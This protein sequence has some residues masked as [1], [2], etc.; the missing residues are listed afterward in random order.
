MADEE[1]VDDGRALRCGR[2]TPEL[3][4]RMVEIERRSFTNPWSAADF[5]QVLGDST[6]VCVGMALRETLIGY[7]IG[8]LDG[9]DFHLANLAVDV[10][11]RRRGWGGRLLYTALTEAR[12]RKCQSCSLEVRATNAAASEF[13]RKRGFQQVA[14]RLGYYRKPRENALIM[15]RTIENFRKFTYLNGHSGAPIRMTR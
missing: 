13:Y 4:E 14:V 9:A 3:I 10:P 7:V 15:R 5:R 12:M 6:A 1:L 11:Y 2:L 8:Y